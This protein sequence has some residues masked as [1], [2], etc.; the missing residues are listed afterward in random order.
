MNDKQGNQQETVKNG[1]TVNEYFDKPDGI[2]NQ[3]SSEEN[4]EL[5]LQEL[6]IEFARERAV[7]AEKISQLQEEN[8]ILKSR[9]EASSKKYNRDNG[10]KPDKY[11]QLVAFSSAEPMSTSKGYLA[12]PFNFDIDDELIG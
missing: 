3:D 7:L 6:A 2:V 11:T 10:I 1:E 12:L 4:L 5:R 9:I 8:D